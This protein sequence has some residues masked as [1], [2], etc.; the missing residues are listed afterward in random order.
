MAPAVGAGPDDTSSDT[1]LPVATSVPAAGDSLMTVPA[2]TVLLDAVVTAPT[3]SDAL[4]MAV[5]AAP[6]VRPTTL[7]TEAWA[8]PGGTTRAPP[9]PPAARAPPARGWL[10]THP[11]R[12]IAPSR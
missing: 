10:V 8:R 5:D 7:G 11:A 2:G 1:A 3:V 9:P 6:R 4:I 12:P